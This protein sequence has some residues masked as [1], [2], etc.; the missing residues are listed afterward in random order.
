MLLQGHAQR[1]GLHTWL[2]KG[3]LWP[4][5]FPSH[6]PCRA[7]ALDSHTW[8]RMDAGGG[9]DARSGA[10]LA[11]QGT[12]LLLSGG[13]GAGERGSWVQKADAWLLDLSVNPLTW[14][15]VRGKAEEQETVQVRK[16]TCG[17]LCPSGVDAGLEARW[18]SVQVPRPS[19]CLLAHTHRPRAGLS[20]W[21]ARACCRRA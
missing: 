8:Q 7:F 11:I 14:R 21:P 5:C 10:S 2:A 12:T 16:I 4:P 6:L 20:S 18:T 13:M 19:I 9:L 1:Q 17:H 15:K 3:D